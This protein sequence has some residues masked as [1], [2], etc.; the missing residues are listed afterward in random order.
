MKETQ[1]P[2]YSF[3]KN[4]KLCIH[5][6]HTEELFTTARWQQSFNTPWKLGN[7]PKG[8]FPRYHLQKNRV[9]WQRN[10]RFNGKIL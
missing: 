4:R 5:E 2:N 3:P 9:S 6:K 7:N 1:P 10:Y 8:Q